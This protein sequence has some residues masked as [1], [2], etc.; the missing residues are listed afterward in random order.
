MSQPIDLAR[1]TGG[2]GEINASSLQA[3]T[4]RRQLQMY[5]SHF[6][7]MEQKL[8][9]LYSDEGYAERRAD[10]ASTDAAQIAGASR[11]RVEREM[12]RYGQAPTQREARVIERQAAYSGGQAQAA[13]AN[14][15]RQQAVGLQRALGQ[16]I[17]TM[18]VATSRQGAQDLAQAA[19][20]HNTREREYEQAKAQYKANRNS[21]MTQG[22]MLGAMTGN[23]LYALAGAGAG[24]YAAS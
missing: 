9:D 24:Y 8:L 22:L 6:K 20:M 7:P 10:Q 15:A 18:G 23:P 4:T 17:A 3:V 12:S 1:Y 14:E 5:D 16:D 13:S 2:N 11:G 19:Q 21:A